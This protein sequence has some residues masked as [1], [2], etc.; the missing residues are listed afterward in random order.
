MKR[1][2]L[3]T[4]F[5]EQIEDIQKT[6][7][8]FFDA[9]NLFYRCL[10][11]ANTEFQQRRND[12]LSGQSKKEWFEKDMFGYWKHLVMGSF[13]TTIQ[14]KKPDRVILAVDGKDYWRKSI[15][16]DYKANR[17]QDRDSSDINFDVFFPIMSELINNLKVL[18]SNIFVL[19]INRCEADD[20][21][22]IITKHLSED[23]LVIQE[24][25]SAD[26]DF[27]QLQ[28]YKNVRQYN[29]I[30]KQFIKS[31]NPE[32]DLDIKIIIGDSGDNI[33]GIQHRCGEKT[34]AK[35]LD[36]GKCKGKTFDEM[37]EDTEIKEKFK[38][39]KKLID[40]E[41]IPENLQK[42]ILDRYNNYEIAPID[43]M[44]IWN[45]LTKERLNKLSDDWQIYQKY[46]KVLK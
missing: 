18:F 9:H 35:L 17:K 43:S 5:S 37:L 19:K 13:L 14:E 21:V 30:K 46:I 34:A 45:W 28:K 2:K 11:V 32:R 12:Y 44:K 27:L 24:I 36:G 33:S 20:I 25:I 8:L 10:Y 42:N 39:N 23:N 6:H 3:S 22:A 40:F 38:R 1:N 15:S 4:F 29:P 31:I 7:I 41:Y 26:K 16:S